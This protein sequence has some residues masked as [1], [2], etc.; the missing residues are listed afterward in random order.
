MGAQ[1]VNRMQKQMHVVCD[2]QNCIHTASWVD[3]GSHSLSYY[4]EK[5]AEELYSRASLDEWRKTYK[6][7]GTLP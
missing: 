2:R 5:H 6:T 4:C 1:P 7:D 3:E